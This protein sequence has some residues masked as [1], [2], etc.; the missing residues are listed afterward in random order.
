MARSAE[1][2]LANL[3]RALAETGRMLLA[4]GHEQ[5]GAVEDNPQVIADIARKT[6]TTEDEARAIYHLTEAEQLLSV[7][8]SDVT[9]DLGTIMST[10]NTLTPSI[11]AS[12]CGSSGG[13]IPKDGGKLPKAQ[14]TVS[15]L[16]VKGRPKAFVL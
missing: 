14:S 9:K 13:I 1:L 10:A 16:A 3:L 5:E 15:K 12:P 4:I 2:E 8:Y 6:G 7:I 11:A